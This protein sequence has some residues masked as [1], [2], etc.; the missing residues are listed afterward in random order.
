[1]WSGLSG[2]QTLNEHVP[3]SD[4][5]ISRRG[6]VRDVVVGCKWTQTTERVGKGHGLPP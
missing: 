2:L 4:A 5:S 6:M 1:M 3:V